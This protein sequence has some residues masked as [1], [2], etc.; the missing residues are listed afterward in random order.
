LFVQAPSAASSPTAEELEALTRRVQTAVE[1]GSDSAER[2]YWTAR[3]NTE[4]ELARLAIAT[5]DRFLYRYAE[6]EQG[7]ENVRPTS[8]AT[9]A[10]AGLGLATLRVQQA[11]FGDAEPLLRR[12]VESTPGGTAVRA[13]ALMY[14]ASVVQRTV[15]IDSALALFDTAERAV[16]PNDDWLRALVRCNTLVARVRKADP[17]AAGVARPMSDTAVRVGNRRA[18]AACLAALAQDQERRSHADSA[19]RTFEQVAELQRQTRNLAALA[20]TRQWLGYVATSR[21]AYYT[22]RPALEEAVA[23]GQRTGALAASAWAELSL[24]DIALTFGDLTSAGRY[25]RSAATAFVRMGDRSG[26]VNARLH[27]GD[28][29]LLNRAFPAARS[30]FE[31]VLRDA[32][33]V[34]PS[35]AVHARGRLAA[36]AMFEGDWAG[37]ERELNTALADAERFNMPQWRA[38]DAYARAT[39]SLIRG[40]LD[41]SV[42]RFNHFAAI[43]KTFGG[44][45][46]M[47]VQTRLAEAHIRAGRVGQGE[48][49][50]V[51]AGAFADNMRKMLP[52]RD[53]QAAV[54]H[55]RSLDWDRDLGFATALAGLASAGH[56]SAAF[57]IAEQRRAWTL[58]EGLVRRNVLAGTSDS[59]AFVERL[60]DDVAVRKV[61]PEST[62]V[63]AFVTGR[64]R[65][66]TTVFLLTREQTSASIVA[67]IDDHVDDLER[68]AG[69]VAAGEIPMELGRRLGDALLRAA[70]ERVP[71]NVRRLV[72]VPDGLLHRLPFDVL[73]LADGRLLVDRFSLSRAPSVAVASSWWSAP[74]RS[75]RPRLLAFGDPVGVR[76][77][78]GEADSVPPRLPVA[79][80]EAQRVGR[81]ADYAEVFT[82]EEARESR[83]RRPL[84]DVGILHFA[85]HADVEEWSLMRSALLLAPGENEDGRVTT[86]ELLGLRLVANLVVLSACR[87][88]S[89]AVLAGE[90]LHGLTIPLLEAG[91]A[92]VVATLWQV[93]DRSVSPMIEHFYN[94]LANGMSVGDALHRAKLKAREQG[95]SPAIWASFLLTG[96]A[97][98]TTDLRTPTPNVARY[99]IP[100]VLL[101]LAVAYWAVVTL[102][103]RNAERRG[104]P[105]ASS[106]A[107]HQR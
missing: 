20:V 39:L 43:D 57:R 3:L 84:S 90:G 23:L 2:A 21:G 55:K 103:R 26:L 97:R 92:S 66:P 42:T 88:G 41:E 31:Q 32:P 45:N 59:A 102:R 35:L 38:Q 82:G 86:E 79:A 70:L 76:F 100:L 36:V 65:E 101:A 17:A 29:A 14:L 96:D 72:I 61:L 56:V 51:N 27:E 98:A 11:R 74:P 30:A 68:F 33:N 94:E 1:A 19:Y 64:G 46:R 22:A 6:A 73:V 49:H 60:V 81:Y 77:S 93:G 85:T 78:E 71:P 48:Q 47:D 4:G 67:P 83:I 105:S 34:F 62:A 87:S 89:G 106:P 24:A 8:E 5:L 58:L 28:V 69:L 99:A 104:V 10:Y 80:R 40:Q 107:T 44:L 12:V 9:R 91:A 53:L 50:L 52:W 37:A 63:L 18:A 13:Q 7:F 75:P 15:S 54:L 16:P 25:A 95:I